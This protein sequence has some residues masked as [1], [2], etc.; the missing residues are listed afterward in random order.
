MKSETVLVSI[1]LTAC[2][3]HWV[4]FLHYLYIRNNFDS[5]TDASK[6]LIPGGLIQDIMMSMKEYEE[7]KTCASYMKIVTKVTNM[8]KVRQI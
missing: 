6:P 8:E 7:T 1:L 4:S 5:Q 3:I 2:T